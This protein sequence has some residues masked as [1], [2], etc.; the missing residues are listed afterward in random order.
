[1]DPSGGKDLSRDGVSKSHRGGG[2]LPRNPQDSSSSSSGKSDP[3]LA[4]PGPGGGYP[5]PY[6][7]A[8]IMGHPQS[9]GHLLLEGGGSAGGR[10][11]D[12]ANAPS[13]EKT[14]SK[15]MSVQEEE[16]RALGKTTMTAANFI[17]AIIMRQISCDTGMPEA[18]P[19][20]ANGTCEAAQQKAAAAAMEQHGL[21]RPPSE[22]RLSP[23]QQP[24]SPHVK[25]S[26]RVVTLAQHISEVITKDYT[27]QQSQ[28]GSQPS[29]FGYHSS[30]GL[31][32]TRP[33]S[34]PQSQ[35]SMQDGPGERLRDRSPPQSKQSPVSLS[36]DGIEPV[37]PPGGVSEA[38]SQGTSYPDDQGE[39][40]M[41]SRSPA[42]GSQPPAFFSKL[43]ESNS[44]IVKVKKQ[45]MIKKIGNES[46]FNPAQP[47]TEIFNMPASTTTAGPVNVRS[48]PAPETGGNTIGLEAIIRKALMGKYDEQGED[49]QPT[50]MGSAPT[51]TSGAEGHQEDSYSGAG[52]LKSSG[53]SRS[54]GRKAKSPGP[55]LSGGERPSSVS[56]VHSEGDCNRR[57]PLTNRVW[58]D[59]PSSTGPTPFPYNPL[60]M[61]MR[62][63]MGPGPAPSPTQT[64]QSGQGAGQ[65]RAWE[66]EPKPLLCSQYETLSDSE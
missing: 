53:G 55:G 16:L 35:G 10:G 48:H 57:T 64:N 28:M 47:G 37:S 61:T 27:R 54:N 44:T 4:S 39:Q 63:P 2:V 56:S 9:R 65:G 51:T 34:A 11:G 32:L 20:A 29:L 58:E 19:L 30:P 1:M 33:P 40:V 18:G 36:A 25:G 62:L 24:Q 59:R 17:N 14:Q 5:S 21:Y 13:R 8:A 23:G 49:R 41:G 52:K 66:E 46:D 43:T 22:E 38:E 12:G 31:D 42:S 3:K 50:S 26:Q 60:T 7:P 15:A 45:E 6:A